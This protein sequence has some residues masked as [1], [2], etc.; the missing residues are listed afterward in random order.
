MWG[1]RLFQR[2]AADSTIHLSSSSY[3]I[4]QAFDFPALVFLLKT[5]G[6][7]SKKMGLFLTLDNVLS[8]V[9]LSICQCFNHQ[10]GSVWATLVFKQ[11]LW[12]ARRH[13]NCPAFKDSIS[14]CREPFK[15]SAGPLWRSIRAPRGRQSCHATS[16]LKNGAPL[17]YRLLLGQQNFGS[18]D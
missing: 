1:G 13:S 15:W 4:S 8:S 16:K 18:I 6:L 11:F 12:Q 17:L 2:T 14:I 3:F 9:K 5:R 7:L 10:T